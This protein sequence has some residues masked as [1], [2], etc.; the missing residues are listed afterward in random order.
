[1]D[2]Q[3]K[4]YRLEEREKMTMKTARFLQDISHIYWE[5]AK[6][7]KSAIINF[8]YEDFAWT[9]QRAAIRV[10]GIHSH[11]FDK[12]WKLRRETKNDIEEQARVLGYRAT[13]TS[14][15]KS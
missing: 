8:L 6:R 13:L 12:Y 15:E 7:S 4:L 9:F 11:Y 1:M 2:L 10:L 14:L 3:E 5:R